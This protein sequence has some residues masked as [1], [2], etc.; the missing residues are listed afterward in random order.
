MA[1]LVLL[2]G[3]TAVGGAVPAPPPEIDPIPVSML[4]DLGS[5]QVLWARQPDLPF[6][7]ASVTKVMTAYVAFEQ[8]QHGTL[9]PE[10]EYTVSEAVARDWQGKGTSLYLKAGDKVS[11]DL[12]IR[13]ITTV[14]AND[15]AAVLA[16]GFAGSLPRWAQLMNAE[17]RRLGMSNSHFNTPNGWM[18]DGATY[19]SAR[20]LVRLAN[21]MTLRHPDLYRRYIGHK[22]LLWVNGGARN[23]DP[24]IG[25]FPGADGIKTGY[26]REAGYNY[27]GSAERN[28]QRLAMVIAGAKSG[29]ERAAA[30]K[31]LM[32]WGFSAWKVRPLFAAGKT[33]GNA[34]VQDGTTRQ[35]ALV[36]PRAIH[37]NLPLQGGTVTSL[38]IVYQG[39]LV[40]PIVKGDK[41]AELEIRTSEGE[42]SRVP[43]FAG[44]SVAKAGTWDRIVNGLVSFLP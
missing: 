33:V 19:V 42:P 39:P 23:H 3:T 1:L 22:S 26:T 25:K 29:P 27:L 18:D 44:A 4:V 16:E 17:A 24:L 8:L 28:G 10:Q 13:G 7:P 36:S 20:D 15:G 37:A 6:V 41:V 31:A 32:E 30:A 43:L 2:L 14:S 5:G 11:V 35:V 34:T 21:A 40:A 38:R 12:L 9:K